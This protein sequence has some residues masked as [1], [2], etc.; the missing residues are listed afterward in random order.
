MLHRLMM[1]S[2][3]TLVGQVTAQTLPGL[4]IAP[5]ANP[6]ATVPMQSPAEELSLADL[7]RLVAAERERLASMPA[8]GHTPTNGQPTPVPDLPPPELDVSVG[9]TVSIGLGVQQVSRIQSPFADLRIQHQSTA[10]I[11][12]QGSVVYISPADTTPFVIYL[13]DRHDSNR[14]VGLLVRPHAALPPVQVRLNLAGASLASPVIATEPVSAGHQARIR[15]VLRAIALDAAPSGFSAAPISDLDPPITCRI[16]GLHIERQNAW[17]GSDMTV[18]TARADN[19]S[20]GIIVIDESAC[21]NA[22]VLAVAAYPDT[23]LWPGTSTTL[24]VVVH[25]EASATAGAATIGAAD[26]D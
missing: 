24:M 9:K 1:I 7:D 12:K 13:E 8:S 2:A 20:A 10:S 6:T 15:S 25:G 19:A 17:H 5:V 22:Q 21:A 23:E 18:L 4:P 26:H 11:K 14:T 16:P 3:M